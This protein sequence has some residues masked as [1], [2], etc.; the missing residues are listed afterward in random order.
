MI[1]HFRFR[2][3]KFELNLEKLCAEMNASHAEI[4]N[5]IKGR[6]E[7]YLETNLRKTRENQINVNQSY[8]EDVENSLRELKKN[9]IYKF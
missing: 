6:L 9:I 2:K 7:N 8:F 1:N 4:Q 5:F 3:S